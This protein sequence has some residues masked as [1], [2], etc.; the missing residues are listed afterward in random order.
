MNIINT[1]TMLASIKGKVFPVTGPVVAQRVG[2][3]IA[4]LFYDRGTRRRWV[5]SSTP[6]P[7]FTPGKDPVPIVQEAGWAP[8]PSGQAE[9]LA[10]PGF[11][12]RTVQPVAQSLHRLSY[13]PTT[14]C[15]REGKNRQ[16]FFFLRAM[17]ACRGSG[18]LAPLFLHCGA[19]WRVSVQ[20]KFEKSL[21]DDKMKQ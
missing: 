17:M 15:K 13:R 10:P 20:L 18:V 4:L 9:N 21:Q 7:Y 3:G 14:K 5:V 1:G 16:F 11:D 6:Q 2:R 8:G 12:P 19:G